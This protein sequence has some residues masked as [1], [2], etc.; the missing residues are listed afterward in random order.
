MPPLR[1]E[2]T[3]VYKHLPFSTHSPDVGSIQRPQEELRLQAASWRYQ[4]ED[5]IV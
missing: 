4:A 1:R 3:G 2:V 5:Y